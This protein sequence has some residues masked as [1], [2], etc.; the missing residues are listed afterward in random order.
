LE[1]VNCFAHLDFSKEL[2]MT[3]KADVFDKIATGLNMLSE[4][5]QSSTVSR[6]FFDSILQSM[7]DMLL[8]LNPDGNIRTVNPSTADTL[9]YKE[10][11]LIGLPFSTLFAEE[12]EEK[13]K[14]EKVPFLKTPI[15]SLIKK[16][17]IT[18]I[19]LT[20]LS[21]DG[22]KI[23][24][25][26]SGSVMK[27]DQKEITGVVC[28]AH[29]I[30]ERKKAEQEK[31]RLVEE[32]IKIE[33]QK[34]FELEKVNKKLSKSKQLL[35]EERKLST[36][37]ILEEQEKER[38]RLALDIHDSLLQRLTALNMDLQ[39]IMRDKSS[40]S[41]STKERIGMSIDQ[42]TEII[43]ETR[44]IS[45]N[46]VPFALKDF[47][48]KTSVEQLIHNFN[49]NSKIK[50]NYSADELNGK[51][52]I[53]KQLHIFRVIQEALHNAL[54]HSKAKE[55]N[56]NIT[57]LNDKLINILIDDDGLGFDYKKKMKEKKGMGLI[58]MCE[59]VNILDG[60]IEIYSSEK[61]G[62]SIILDVPIND[63]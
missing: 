11:E 24:V 4:E 15:E 28:V 45:H 36:T 63:N 12:E 53:R 47:G 32:K 1:A 3:N 8:V 60:N 26:L 19:E 20:F 22:S 6:N 34:G 7:P 31:K 37:A 33:K 43:T 40:T 5:L 46:L 55:I 23:P 39:H 57:L 44:N 54:R 35:L 17:T 18:N 51:L 29:N 42:I 2:P 25:H 49:K 61:S 14:E 50:I 52:D 9:G 56:I 62:T 21:K 59:R 27:N 58:N 13:N 30:T 48:L 10:E 41:P 16:G 38:N